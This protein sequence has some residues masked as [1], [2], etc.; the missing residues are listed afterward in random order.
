MKFKKAKNL[1][2]QSYNAKSAEAKNVIA[3]TNEVILDIV[4]KRNSTIES[5]DEGIIQDYKNGLRS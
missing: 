4:F 3:V 1:L 5:N 2:T